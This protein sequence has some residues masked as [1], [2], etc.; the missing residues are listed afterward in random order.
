[1]GN[2][3]KDENR[4]ERRKGREENRKMRRGR[5]GEVR[6]KGNDKREEK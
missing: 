2:D 1:M 4:K 6:G 5:E 3:R